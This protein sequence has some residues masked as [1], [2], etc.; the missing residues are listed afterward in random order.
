[1][2]KV[3]LFLSFFLTFQLTYS[4]CNTNT[5]ICSGTNAGPF[6][7]VNQGPSVSTCLDWLSGSKIGYIILNI[8]GSGNLNMLINGNSSSGFLDVAVFNIPSGQAPCTAIQNTSNQILCNYASSSSGCAQFG[9]QFGCASNIGTVPVTAGQQLMIVVENWSGSSSSFTLQMAT[10]PGSAT[11]GLPDATINPV[12]NLCVSSAPVQLTAVSMGGTWSGPGVSATGMFN[13]ATAGV[14]AH[15]I[16]YNVGV[17][18][19]NST[20]TRVI[21]VMANPV[22]NL[23]SNSPICVGESLTIAP[24]TTVNG[25]YAWTGP[26]GFTSSQSAVLIPNVTATHAGTYKLDINMWGCSA[27]G[28]VNVVINPNVTIN[29]VAP[30]SL[31]LNDQSATLTANVTSSGGTTPA[32]GVWSGVGITDSINGTFNPTIAGVGTHTVTYTVSGFCG[33][34]A[35]KDIVVKPHPSLSLTAPVTAACVPLLAKATVG[36]NMALDSVFIDFGNGKFGDS[37]GT[38]AVNYNTV[39][40]FDVHIWGQSQGCA[41]DSLYTDFF[42]T[43]PNPNA[44]PGVVAGTATEYEPNFTFLNTSTGATH[45]LWSFGDGKTSTDKTPTHKYPQIPGDYEVTLYVVSD[46]GCRDSA[47]IQIRV[48]EDVIFYVP[49]AFTPDG[50]QFNNVFKPIMASGYRE[51]SYVFMVYNRWGQAVFESHD[52]HYGWDGTYN[53]EICQDGVYV[54]SIYFKAKENS[55]VY[56]KYGTVTLIK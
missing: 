51:D 48:I 29:I 4:Q 23:V 7:F 53:G 11:A 31:C 52:P 21:T 18:P 56:R 25:I 22:V 44:E 49:N 42:C 54:W 15:T 27:S 26:N 33:N 17:A 43:Q 41:T 16:T 50:D 37:L 38:Y 1:M 32:P 5:S 8:S 6:T 40:C 35:T 34:A 14:G 24:D 55:D 9:G 12:G 47:K 20:A 10:T 46:F 30:T 36:S 13:P 39:N 28:T 2:K 3:L 45:W 19:C